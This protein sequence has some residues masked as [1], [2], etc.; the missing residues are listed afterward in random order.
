MCLRWAC[1]KRGPL[2]RRARTR[3]PEW[4]PRASGMAGGSRDASGCG[5]IRARRGKEV[6]EVGECGTCRLAKS[7][8]NF[9]TCRRGARLPVHTVMGEV[10]GVSGRPRGARRLFFLE[11]SR[12]CRVWAP[13]RRVVTSSTRTG[14]RVVRRSF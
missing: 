3:T 5:I 12:H 2:A 4:G 1:S 11:V 10:R 8:H 7:R 13:G 9:Q 14:N 6:R